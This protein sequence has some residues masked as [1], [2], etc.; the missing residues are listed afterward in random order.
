MFPTNKRDF[1]S[2]QPLPVTSGRIS[3]FSADFIR[4]NDV[5]S[6]VVTDEMSRTVVAGTTTPL[7]FGVV[8]L[9]TENWAMLIWSKL[10]MNNT[11]LTHLL[12]RLLLFNADPTAIMVGD[13]VPI[14]YDY[15]A[16]RNSFLGF[17]DYTAWVS[18][19][20]SAVSFGVPF[21]DNLGMVFPAGNH[22]YGILVY[23]GSFYTPAALQRFYFQ[24][25]VL[26]S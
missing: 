25:G 2:Q 13:N 5:I 11:S 16:I 9:T 10:T 7:D 23:L 26:Q 12:L 14:N 22:L 15:V 21:V 6:Y 20:A 18:G 17:I 4:P 1:S 3:T 8:T 24:V 19:T